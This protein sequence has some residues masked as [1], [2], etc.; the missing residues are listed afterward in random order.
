VYDA[1]IK[2][3]NERTQFGVK[4][5]SFQLIQDKLVRMMGNIQAMLHLAYRVTSLYE[6]NLVTIGMVAM[7]KAWCSKLGREVCQLGREAM[8]GNG[9]LIE[10]YA[11]KGLADM[12]AVY[13][14]E[15][16]YDINTLVCGRELTGIS[17]F[18]VK[19]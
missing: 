9:I 10:N 7:T 18:K 13:T 15:G 17:A 4:I 12:E 11:I 8:G 14:Y 16:T 6:R 1:T 19:A 5:T 3:C 2:Y